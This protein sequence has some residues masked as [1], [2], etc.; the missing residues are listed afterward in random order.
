MRVLLG[1]LYGDGESLLLHGGHISEP[2]QRYIVPPKRNGPD[3]TVSE[4]P[5]LPHQAVPLYGGGSPYGEEEKP[6]VNV[7]Y[8][9]SGFINEPPV[10]MGVYRCKHIRVTWI[11][12]GFR[13]IEKE[14]TRAHDPVLQHNTAAGDNKADRQQQEG[15]EGNPAPQSSRSHR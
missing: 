10:R 6:V 14:K 13:N 1:K 2:E 15:Q 9:G 3:R 8:A 5:F 11:S 7:S 12:A 4:E